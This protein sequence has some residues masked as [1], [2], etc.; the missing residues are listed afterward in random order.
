SKDIDAMKD[1]KCR[2]RLVASQGDN[3]DAISSLCQSCGILEDS[4]IAFIKSI[5][6]HAD[7]EFSTMLR[8]ELDCRR[9]R[10]VGHD[11]MRYAVHNV[12]PGL[13]LFRHPSV[14]CHPATRFAN[15]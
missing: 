3:I 8:R 11:L 13:L 4:R 10:F 15:S 6:H 12:V 7:P 1:F 2:K 5:S 9:G 14:R